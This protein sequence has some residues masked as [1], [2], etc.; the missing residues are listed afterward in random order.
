MVPHTGGL[1]TVKLLLNS[2]V[3]TPGAQFTTIDTNDVY[4]NTLMDLFKYMKLELSD[5]QEDFVDRH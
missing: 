1:I 3:S 2:V 5:L 4:L